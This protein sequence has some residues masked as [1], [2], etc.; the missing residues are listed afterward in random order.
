MF[1]NEADDGILGLAYPSLSSMRRTPF[2]NTA[3]AQGTLRTAE[4]AFKL[5]Q[6]GSELFLGGSNS[7]LYSGNFESHSVTGQNGFWQIGGG[8]VSVGNNV[9]APHPLFSMRQCA[10]Q[11]CEQKNVVSNFLTIVDSGTTII[12]GPLSEVAAMYQSIP[13]SSIYDSRNG[14]YQYPCNQRPTVSFNWGGKDW[15]ISADK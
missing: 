10:D 4:F 7:A 2:V 15:T 13:G 1:G 12:Y 9:C 3:K 14:F 11:L 6:S 8:S 5:A